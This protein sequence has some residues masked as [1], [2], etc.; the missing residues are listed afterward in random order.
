MDDFGSGH[1]SLYHLQKLPMDTLKIDQTFIRDMGKKSG[2]Y[3]IV[4]SI[5]FLAEKLGIH[6]VAE[7]VESEAQRKM[8]TD[9]NCDAF[10]GYLVSEAI[11]SEVFEKQFLNLEKKEHS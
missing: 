6:T 3:A 7:G 4:E 1:S 11:D 2:D 5:I 9:L 10:Q 8:L